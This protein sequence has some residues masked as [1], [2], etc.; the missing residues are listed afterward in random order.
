MV[1]HRNVFEIE[2]RHMFDYVLYRKPYRHSIQA[3]TIDLDG[4]PGINPTRALAR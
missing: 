2:R 4:S 3:F 1:S